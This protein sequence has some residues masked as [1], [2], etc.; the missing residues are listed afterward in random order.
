[1]VISGGPVRTKIRIGQGE[2]NSNVYLTYKEGK[3]LIK[4]VGLPH[5]SNPTLQE[6]AV[7]ELSDGTKNIEM[8]HRLD[9]NYV[10]SQIALLR[11]AYLMMFRHF[12]YA[13]VLNRITEP[14]RKQ[15]REPFTE[16]SILSGVVRLLEPIDQ[17]A[18]TLLTT[19]EYLRCFWVKLKLSRKIDCNVGV[20]LPGVNQDCA[21][22]YAKWANQC[23]SDK[24]G[25]VHIPYV[26]EHI[27][28]PKYTFRVNDIW[29]HFNLT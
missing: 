17:S 3:P 5:L 15:I 8:K 9:Y 4:I 1:M 21:E 16:S 23:G 13:Y 24:F 10:R 14:L 22:L 2:F 19:P 7:K 20:A 6:Q 28:N 27:L 29:N 18:V 26:Q 12:G 25:Y 11:S